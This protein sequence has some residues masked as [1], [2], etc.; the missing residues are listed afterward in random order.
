MHPNRFF[1][2]FSLAEFRVPKTR[3]ATVLQWF[4]MVPVERI[5]L[6]IFGL[7]N[8]YSNDIVGIASEILPPNS[9]RCGDR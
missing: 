4:L 8:Q 5:E 2:A 1:E 3:E 7:Q 9:R 6:P